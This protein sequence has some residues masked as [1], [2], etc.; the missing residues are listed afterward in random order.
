[1][2]RFLDSEGL[3][4]VLT[5]QADGWFYKRNVSNVPR[6][7]QGRALPVNSP[8][9]GLIRATFEPVQ[10][11]ATRPSLAALANGR[12]QFVDLAGE[13][14]QCLV[15]F[16]RPMSGYSTRGADD[17]WQPFVPFPSSP[18]ITWADPNLK[19]LDSDGDGRADVLVSE[20]EVFTGIRRSARAASR[21]RKPS[22]S[23]SMRMKGRR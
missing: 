3:S 10:L 8:A 12:P 19:V 6:D 17:E 14:Q 23:R 7:D 18:N 5:E 16:D 15:Q 4:G 22:A 11:V 9:P 20:D 21:R 1:M 13:D 2:A